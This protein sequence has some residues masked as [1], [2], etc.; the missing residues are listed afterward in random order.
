MRKL[1]A[2]MNMTLDAICDHT[3]G[4]ADD[5]LHEHYNDIL[6]NAGALI[7][8]RVTY[9]LMESHWPEVVKNP[10]GNKSEDDFAL[11]IDSIPKI[12]FSR[13]LDSVTWENTVLLKGNVKEEVLKLKEQPG[14]DIF[15]G[16]PGMIVELLN[17]DLIDE[18]WLCIHP[19]IQGS[20]LPLFKQINDRT[21]LK[22][23]HTKTL[24]GGQVAL[25]Y[26]R[27]KE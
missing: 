21:V 22:L 5:G 6:R 16:S 20:G 9:Q 26:E 13:K 10:T 1:I 4:I 25:Y 24:K 3:A 12:V 27:V 7:Y 2:A 19:V 11:L 14:K 23:L 15:V 18:Y 8:G 17:L